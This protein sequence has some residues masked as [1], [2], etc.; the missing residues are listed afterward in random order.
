MPDKN[1]CCGGFENQL[2]CKGAVAEPRQTGPASWSSMISVIFLSKKLLII[3]KFLGRSL[4]L[5]G[6]GLRRFG[7]I[8]AIL[9]TT[10]TYF[11]STL[12]QQ[13]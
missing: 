1:P 11:L 6:S 4:T 3:F 13:A 7:V 9:K 12:L 8:S 2:C 5:K 10:Q